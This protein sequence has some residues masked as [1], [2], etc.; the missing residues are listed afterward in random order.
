MRAVIAIIFSV[1]TLLPAPAPDTPESDGVRLL[2][3]TERPLDHRSDLQVEGRAPGWQRVRVEPIGSL[4]N[5]VARLSRDLG[6]RV[7]LERLYP[8]LGPESEPRFDDQWGLENVGQSGGRPDADVD[9][10]DAWP[11]ATGEGAVVA[12]I[13]SGI[14]TDNPELDSRIWVNPGEIPGDSV[15]NDANGFRDDV[16]GWDFIGNDNDPR[17]DGAGPDDGHATLIAGIIAAEVNGVGITGIAPDATLMNVRACDDGFCSSFEVLQAIHYAV[18]NGAR[19]INLSFGGPVPRSLGDPVMEDAMDYALAKGVLV[20]TAAGNTPPGELTANEDMLPAEYPHSNNISVAASDR[21]DGL[22]DF[23]Y[24]SPDIDIAAPGEQ[25]ITTGLD[26]YYSVSGTSFSAPLVAGTAALLLDK[27]TDMTLD[28]LVDRIKG[29]ADRPPAIGTKTEAGR[30]NTGTALAKEFIDTLGH[31]F[32]GDIDW[33][34]DN[35]I[36]KGCNPP[37]NTLFCPDEPVSREVMAAFLNRYL[38]L[39]PATKDWFSDDDGSIFEDDINRLAE[40]GITRGC[41]G[42][43][44]CPKTVVDRGQ[45]AAFLVRAFDLSDDGGGNLFVDDNGS[46]FEHDIDILGTAGITKGCNPPTN[47]RYCPGL[48]V[49]RGAM[50]AFLHRA[51]TP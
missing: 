33:A 17:P 41:G 48:E 21:D 39:E 2:V 10:I 24:Y 45:M 8:L 29:F 23:S 32:E 36:T 34:A 9:A 51:P 47:D 44:F 4:E 35:S 5:T 43:R 46:I 38:D 13:D 12:V 42:T 20:V 28:E 22:S 7:T 50:T 16:E 49:D 19:V 6:A 14:D 18:D 37:V 30:L 31:L 27:K 26:R 15:D 1:S 11:I 25:I 3:A 40:G